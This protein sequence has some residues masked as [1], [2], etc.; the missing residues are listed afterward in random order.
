MVVTPRYSVTFFAFGYLIWPLEYIV[1]TIYNLDLPPTFKR[2]IL[3]ASLVGV[4]AF[5]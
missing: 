3:Y 5:N 1:V 4:S 2:I